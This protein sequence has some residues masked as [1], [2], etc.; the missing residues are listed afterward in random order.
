MK[1]EAC[2]AKINCASRPA[3]RK[4]WVV[5]A[6]LLFCVFAASPASA[7]KKKK[8]E[9]PPA[10]LPG[11]VNY[12]ARELYAVPLDSSAPITNQIQTLILNHLE[13]WFAAGGAKDAASGK[14]LDVRVRQQIEYAFSELHYPLEG[15]AAVF[16]HPWKNGQLIGA[17]YTL[18]W[19]DFRT[20]NVL[21]LYQYAAGKAR[22]LTLTH[23]VPRTDLHYAFLPATANGDLRLMV[24]G[25]RAGKSQPRLTAIL[26]AFDGAHL[27]SLW[28]THDAYD[29]RLQV[30]PDAVTLR[31]LVESEYVQYEERGQKPPRH[32]A[33]YKVTPQGLTLVTDHEIPF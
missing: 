7:R 29:G 1:P 3:A 2:G 16:T 28:E 21:A 26:Y 9:G 11:R 5:G 14:P 30:A 17:G 4:L 24:Y 10:S 6:I 20:V 31:Y 23:F 22:F 33:V 18:G 13:Q 8:P 25:Y 32:E 15:K 12:L 19:P 27:H